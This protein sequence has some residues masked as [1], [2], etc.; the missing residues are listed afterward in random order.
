MEETLGDLLFIKEID[1]SSYY[2]EK[3]I[4]NISKIKFSSTF[5]ETLEIYLLNGKYDDYLWYQNEEE[6]KKL[7]KELKMK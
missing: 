3:F 1:N 6:K 7:L 5:P 2:T 4:H